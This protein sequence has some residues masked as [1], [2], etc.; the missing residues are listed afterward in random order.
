[1]R[2]FWHSVTTN[3]KQEFRRDKAVTSFVVNCPEWQ[4][5]LEWE[6]YRASLH[7]VK[8]CRRDEV[9][10]NSVRWVVVSL[11]W[12]KVTKER[13][14]APHMVIKIVCAVL[15][16]TCLKGHPAGCVVVSGSIVWW[17]VI[18]NYL[19]SVCCRYDWT[20]T[21]LNQT[22]AKATTY[23]TRVGTR[24]NPTKKNT[25]THCKKPSLKW[26]FWGFRFFF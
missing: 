3:G 19:S 26:V 6:W 11:R 12:T 24:K 20:Q 13:R 18:S 2:F 21:G 15:L 17:C 14:V 25:K 8:G 10:R 16:W 5:G 7:A 9:G 23:S 4:K 1:M 22:P